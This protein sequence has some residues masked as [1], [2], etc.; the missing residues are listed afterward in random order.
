VADTKGWLYETLAECIN[1]EFNECRGL[2][3]PVII[4]TFDGVTVNDNSL[5]FESRL[6]PLIEELCYLLNN[7]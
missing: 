1:N 4:K 3:E 7:F 6:F 5:S 2:E